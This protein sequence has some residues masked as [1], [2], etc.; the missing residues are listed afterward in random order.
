MVKYWIS[1]SLVHWLF[2]FY[3]SSLKICVWWT[4]TWALHGKTGGTDSQPRPRD[5]EDVQPSLP[6]LCGLHHRT[7]QSSWWGTETQGELLREDWKK[8][9]NTGRSQA[10]VQCAHRVVYRAKQLLCLLKCKTLW[11]QSTFV[12][13][14]GDFL[15]FL[16]CRVKWLK[17]TRSCRTMGRRYSIILYI[18]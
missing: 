13:G 10:S 18:V 16:L 12:R 17:P 1:D 15:N 8:S 9:Q 11:W 7:A 5:R 4:R 6:R 3:F 14:V 2:F